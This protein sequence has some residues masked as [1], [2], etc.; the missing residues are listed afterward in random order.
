MDEIKNLIT[1]IMEI[2]DSVFTHIGMDC[3][4]FLEAIGNNDTVI[5]EANRMI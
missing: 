4:A 2:D 5:I 1:T 3:E